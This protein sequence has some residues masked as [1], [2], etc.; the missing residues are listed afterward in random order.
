LD[1]LVFLIFSLRSRGLLGYLI[2]W[3]VGAFFFSPKQYTTP[4]LVITCFLSYG[5]DMV[6]I[7]RF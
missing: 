6:R 5:S 7:S 3:K 4:L 2:D 1:C